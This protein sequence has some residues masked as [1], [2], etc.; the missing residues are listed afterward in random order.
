MTGVRSLS[1]PVYCYLE[2]T[3]ACDN[4]CP[5]CG[6]VFARSGAGRDALP[7]PLDGETWQR[8]LDRLS[9]HVHSLRITGGEPT[10]HPE[11]LEILDRVDAL[12]VPYA[13][14]T[15]GRWAEPTRLIRRLGESRALRSLLISLHGA[16]A[17]AH[18][19]FCGREEAFEETAGNVVRATRAGLTVNTST[20]LTRQNYGQVRAIA[21]LSRT[22]GADHAVFSRPIGPLDGAPSPAQLRH[23]VRTVERLCDEGTPVRWSAC[24]PPCFTPNSSTGCLAGLAFW[25][26]DPWG[27]V[28]PCNHAPLRCGNLLR[29]SVAEIA[30]SAEMARWHA[31]IPQACR[32]CAAYG[33]CHGGCRAQALWLG[34]GRDDLMR[35]PLASDPSPSP[36]LELPREGRPVARFE[37]RV[38]EFGRLLIRGGTVLPVSPGA[39]PLLEGLDGSLTVGEIEERFGTRGLSLVGRLLQEGLVEL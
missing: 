26:I 28:R 33:R 5:G 25:T 8:I 3:A 36:T 14:F 18:A 31:A 23:A 2:L 20:V 13:L 32:T 7:P 27:H 22:L 12:G 38:E 35:A 4:H 17:A 29:R 37:T 19:A 16:D 39:A 6:N 24:V 15:H 1:G 21:H 10:L 30:A 11:F 34:R 9:P